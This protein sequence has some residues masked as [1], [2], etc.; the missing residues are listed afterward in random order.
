MLYQKLNTDLHASYNNINT[1][2]NN[3]RQN[4]I[5]IEEENQ[6]NNNNHNQHYPNSPSFDPYHPHTK[7][8]E[9]DTK[10]DIIQNLLIQLANLQ[11]NQQQTN[12]QNN[13]T[14]SNEVRKNT[15]NNN[16]KSLSFE[17]KN[18]LQSAKDDIPKYNNEQNLTTLIQFLE[19]LEFYL[20]IKKDLLNDIEAP[21]TKTDSG[22]L[23]ILMNQ[24][25]TEG[26]L[27]LFK[28]YKEQQNHFQTENC[29]F[30]R[31]SNLFLSKS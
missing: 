30:S 22:N 14:S 2:N 21:N 27:D 8:V 28:S 17:S 7:K 13:N 29:T 23:I 25:L 19:K 16:K 4:K 6:D 24:K 11:I 9:N 10:F 12:N 1:T 18:N 5:K 26:A 31:I 20:Q 15:S 3:H